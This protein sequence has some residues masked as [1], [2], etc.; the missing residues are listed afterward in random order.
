MVTSSYITAEMQAL[1]EAAREAG[2]TVI[3]FAK[4]IK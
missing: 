3:F 4:T 1:D 2:I